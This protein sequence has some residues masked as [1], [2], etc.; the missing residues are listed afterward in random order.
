M[1]PDIASPK[2][3]KRILCFDF[4]S[5]SGKSDNFS[6]NKGEFLTISQSIRLYLP[7]H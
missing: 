1:D 4:I 6:K 2:G 3:K 5:I 7:V